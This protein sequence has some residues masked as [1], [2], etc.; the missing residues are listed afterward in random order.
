MALATNPRNLEGAR[1]AA[2]VLESS[3]SPEA[4]LWRSLAVELN[5]KST[6]DRLALAK[7]AVIFRDL[8]TATNALE[9]VTEEG[10]QSVEYQTVAGSVFAAMNMFSTAKEH[11]AEA[12]RLDPQNPMPLLDLSMVDIRGTNKEAIAKARITLQSLSVNATNAVLR[13]QAMRELIGDAVRFTNDSAAL[14]LSKDL[15]DAT[16]ADFS[17]R[18]ARLEVLRAAHNSE[19]KPFMTNCEHEASSNPTKLYQLATW[20]QTHGEIGDGLAWLTSLPP[21][22]RTNQPAA[23]L[24]A[25]FQI[26]A[27][28]WS[29]MQKALE[30]QNWAGSDF[31][32]HAF[33]SF[34]LKQLDLTESSKGQ[35]DQALAAAAGQKMNQ[36]MLLKL[37]AS[38]GWQKETEEL[39]WT[40]IRQHPDERWAVQALATIF[41]L[42]SR[43]TSLLNLFRAEVK[44]QPSDLLY[45]NNLAMTALLLGQKDLK[46]DDM[47]REVYQSSPTNSSFASTYA[48]SLFLQ[49]KNPDALRVMEKL[50]EGELENP[51]VAGYY[52]I[53][54]KAN[55]DSAKAQKYLKI[56]EKT[57]HLPE[58]KRLFELA[59]Q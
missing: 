5:P 39:L 26:I 52:G 18:M 16:N 10:K 1:L 21:A 13:H 41:F 15:V 51:S 49:K 17:D 59:R 20:Q 57:R 22:T 6:E 9:G 36:T 14:S 55:G 43:T 42:D 44:S 29:G 37:A 7:A 50:N 12:S 4:M 2:E 30:K 45:K 19:Y 28:D 8:P 40:I 27:K 48:F 35:W 46:P 56:A 11:F 34:A 58:E 3:R 53:I 31:V 23:L 33:L 38:W 54:L 47:A 25:E 32:R 24:S